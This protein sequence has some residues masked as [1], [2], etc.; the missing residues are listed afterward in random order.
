MPDATPADLLRDLAARPGPALHPWL[1][2]AAGDGA[3]DYAD[4]D[5]GVDAFDAKTA[6]ARFL[7]TTACED[8]AGDVV[9]PEGCKGRLQRYADNPT[10]F[11]GHRSYGFPVGSARQKGSD[12]LA[13]Q[14]EPKGLYSHVTFHLAT[15]ESEDVCRLVE[16]G[17]LRAASIGFVP[18]KAKVSRRPDPAED[19]PRNECSFE[20]W[21]KYRFTEW[22][23][24]EWSV[25][26]IPMNP[27]CVRARLEKGFGGKALS[28]FVAQAL[29]PYAQRGPVLVRGGYD[30]AAG[31]QPEKTEPVVLAATPAVVTQA[32]LVRAL[33]ELFDKHLARLSPAQPPA[34]PAPAPAPPAPAPAG[35]GAAFDPLAKDLLAACKRLG[36]QLEANKAA[37]RRV[38][39][40]VD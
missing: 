2:R 28:P 36:E 4:P 14:W 35:Q 5:A 27:E 9:E 37:L 1:A 15:R 16:A 10:V 7:I 40:R 21:V 11:F 23:M 3:A 17:E 25:C 32:D 12:E 29:T 13:F 39:G 18:L 34:P 26:A 33:D 24:L 22:E 38:T 8:R 20:P 30:P 6:T 19:A 31:A